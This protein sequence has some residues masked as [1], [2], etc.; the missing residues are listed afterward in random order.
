MV[1]CPSQVRRKACRALL[2]SRMNPV[3]AP[4]LLMPLGNVPKPGCVPAPGASNVVM[5]VFFSP[6][7][8]ESPSPNVQS[9]SQS[10]IG[11]H[12]QTLDAQSD[13]KILVRVLR[14]VFFM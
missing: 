3:I 7:F 1:K 5:H 14:R 6:A 4:E 10:A 13:F 8:T 11:R 12:G 2:A 9:T